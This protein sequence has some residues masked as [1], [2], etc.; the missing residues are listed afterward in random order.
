[1]I[2]FHVVANIAF[3]SEIKFKICIQTFAW[4]RLINILEK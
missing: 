1:M 4:I 2:E 3:C